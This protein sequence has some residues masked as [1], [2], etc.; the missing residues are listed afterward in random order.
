MKDE[1]YKEKYFTLKSEIGLLR[2]SIKKLNITISNLKAKSRLL[3]NSFRQVRDK[4]DY[5]LKYS[6]G[7]KKGSFKEKFLNE[8]T[9]CI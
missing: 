2:V 1:T 8:Q 6:Y 5:V 7:K 3:N 9:P 4:I